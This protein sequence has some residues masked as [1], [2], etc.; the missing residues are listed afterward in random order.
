MTRR[1]TLEMIS[2]Q[3]T[4][5]FEALTKAVEGIRASDQLYK[6]GVKKFLVCPEVMEIAKVIQKYTNLNV[7]FKNG[8]QVGFATDVI[9][10]NQ[11]HI[12]FDQ[13]LIQLYK[14]HG[15]WKLNLHRDI[16]KVMTDLKSK[17][18]SGGV[19]LKDAKVYGAYAQI[20][21]KIYLP[22]DDMLDKSYLTDAEVAAV[23]LHEIGH[24]FNMLELAGRTATTNQVLSLLSKALDGSVTEQDRV[25]IFSKAAKTLEMD[26]ELTDQ[27][28]KS[29]TEYQLTIVLFDADMRKCKSELGASVYDVNSCEWLADQFASRC[30]A[31]KE[32]VTAL[33]KVFVKYG[34]NMEGYAR[35]NRMQ[36]YIFTY[37][38][39]PSLMSLMIMTPLAIFLGGWCLL[40]VYI[41]VALQTKKND[42][43]DK[44]L[45]RI[46]RIRRETVDRLKD[47]ELDD[48]QRKQILK[49]I[50]GIDAVLAR[51]DLPDY[52]LFAEKVAYFFKPTY[53]AAHKYELLQK[54]LE[55]IASNDLFIKAAQ[56]KTV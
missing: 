17:S 16:E 33:E 40:F 23:L 11:N 28:K 31:S 18:V 30:G 26:D 56:L 25:V 8:N 13:E 3:S 45:S 24:T 47:P 14:D 43:Y 1:L 12:F 49:T 37:F 44:P 20:P 19:S 50:E 55:A 48:D 22:V 38:A 2:Q 51:G 41:L 34:L 9:L 29:K 21:V 10:I 46:N 6:L 15:G 39:L 36:I 52:L 35:M 32:L 42:I 5:F 27:L 4:D 53:R 54:E 7:S